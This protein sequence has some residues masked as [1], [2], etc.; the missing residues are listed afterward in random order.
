MAV[1]RL[2]DLQLL[3]DLAISRKRGAYPA[4]TQVAGRGFE[5]AKKLQGGE[6]SRSFYQAQTRN[7]IGRNVV[8]SISC[9]VNWPECSLF[10][11]VVCLALSHCC[12]GCPVRESIRGGA[13][14]HSPSLSSP[15][16]RCVSKQHPPSIVHP[17]S[18]VKRHGQRRPES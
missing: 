17:L 14:A 15:F 6:D 11:R 16:S 4:E 13:R 1:A 18:S 12:S 9:W 7:G 10:F 5:S 8:H 3:T 2:V